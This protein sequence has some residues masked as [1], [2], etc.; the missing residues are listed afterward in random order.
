MKQ[1]K[2][3]GWKNRATWNVA[4]WLGNDYGLYTAAKDFMDHYQGRAPYAA[5]IRHAGL[6]NNRT[7]D[8]YKWLGTGLSYQELNAMMKELQ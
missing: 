5:F 6:E 7:G 8:G 2:C 1:E 4:L 3:N